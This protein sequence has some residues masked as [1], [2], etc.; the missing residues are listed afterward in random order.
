MH[1]ESL[2]GESQWNHDTSE[3]SHHFSL[4]WEQTLHFHNTQC[5]TVST[6]WVATSAS[7]KFNKV[8]NKECPPRPTESSTS[9]IKQA[10]TKMSG[11]R[12]KHP[13]AGSVMWP[14]VWVMTTSLWHSFESNCSHI[15]SS[16]SR[17]GFYHSRT[18]CS[19]FLLSKCY[20]DSCLHDSPMC[21]CFGNVLKDLRCL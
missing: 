9:E 4:W 21:S 15:R 7:S 10:S 19:T 12:S 20:S 11:R 14:Y 17:K 18:N 5:I 3:D 16:N 1:R 13:P 2:T 8:V 6:G